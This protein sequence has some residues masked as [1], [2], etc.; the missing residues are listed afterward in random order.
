MAPP[1]HHNFLESVKYSPIP[2]ISTLP[3]VDAKV[4]FQIGRGDN[5]ISIAYTSKS[6]NV[7][8]ICMFASIT[9][10]MAERIAE[11]SKQKD[12]AQVFSEL[13]G[14]FANDIVSLQIDGE[15][16][17]WDFGKLPTDQKVEYLEQWFT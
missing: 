10:Q 1:V 17:M 14:L 6:R 4:S 2:V 5:S 7:R 11:I 13:P 3:S 12:G 15:P 8:V 16:W 9:D